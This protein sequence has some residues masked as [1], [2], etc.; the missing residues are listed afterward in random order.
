MREHSAVLCD[1][2]RQELIRD[3]V[4]SDPEARMKPL[5]GGGSSD[6][7]LVEDR[8]RRMVVKRALTRQH[9]KDVWLADVSRKGVELRCL[10]FVGSILPDA[11]PA[12]IISRPDRNYF[13]MQYMDERLVNYKQML[14]AGGGLNRHAEIAGATRSLL[15]KKT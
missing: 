4:P 3:G 1:E 7:Y 15:H 12:I 9:V 2:F 10:E 8:G 6:I 5:T 11:V 14:L 13:A